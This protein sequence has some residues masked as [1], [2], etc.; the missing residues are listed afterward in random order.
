MDPVTTAILAA[1]ASGG[2][3]VTEKLIVDTYEGL[4]SI[5]SKKL[6]DDSKVAEAIVNLETEPEFGTHKMTLEGRI[7]GAKADQ[8]PDIVKAAQALLDQINAQ[9][10]STQHIQNAIGSYIAQAE[11]GSTATVTINYPEQQQ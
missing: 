8:D 4:K 2:G 6:G 10:G 3:K 11:L 7:K 9:P 1:L 5:I